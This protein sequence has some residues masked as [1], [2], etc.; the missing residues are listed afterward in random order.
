MT[1]C[2]TIILV[3]FI[4]IGGSVAIGCK[5]GEEA[6]WNTFGM[7]LLVIAVIALLTTLEDEEDWT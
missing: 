6:G 3:T 2:L 5:F 1:G 4:A 7:F